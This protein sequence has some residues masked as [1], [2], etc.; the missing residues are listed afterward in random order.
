M[1]PIQDL[2]TCALRRSLSQKVRAGRQRGRC[3]A[4]GESGVFT[5]SHRHK[6]K[7]PLQ[8]C[9]TE[10]LGT[11]FQ[12]FCGKKPR[13]HNT[14]N[15]RAGGQ[16]AGEPGL[17]VLRVRASAGASCAA[18]SQA[19][20]QQASNQRSRPLVPSSGQSPVR[21]TSVEQA[22]KT[23]GRQ[24]GVPGGGPQ[25]RRGGSHGGSSEE[26][27]FKKELG[28]CRSLNKKIAD[29]RDKTKFC[30]FVVV[31]NSIKNCCIFT[32]KHPGKTKG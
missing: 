20:V 4:G 32:L 15:L 11:G 13:L 26:K 18:R 17:R 28:L 1:V 25:P 16:Q 3:P 8:S 27:V 23:R 7:A 6:G 24:A 2:L 9:E 21:A 31:V 22:R 14:A 12:K 10:K 29:H 30:G 19:Q 5:E